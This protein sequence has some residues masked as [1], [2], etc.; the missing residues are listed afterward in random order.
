[1]T[2]SLDRPDNSPTMKWQTRTI[3]DL[4]ELAQ[5]RVEAI[6][7]AQ[8]LTRIA[9][10]YVAASTPEQRTWLEF[11]PHDA[12]IATGNFD[13]AITLEMRLPMLE[14]QF[15]ENGKPMP[16]VFDPEEHSPAEVEAWLLVELLHRGID[17][18]VFSKKLPYTIAGLMSGDAED[19]SPRL[20]GPGLI[21]LTALM[22]DAAAVLKAAA[23]SKG[24][25]QASI[26]CLPQNLNLVGP[27]DS[28]SFVFSLGDAESP[29]PYF[30][31][32]AGSS[33]GGGNLTIKAAALMAE[34]DPIAAAMKLR[35]LALG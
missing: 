35:D 24:G 1:M 2:N 31:R 3:G 13:K 32:R 14:L 30:Y 11:R 27:S 9:N 23:P 7:V 28:G 19:Y 25:D 5:A 34:C 33:G 15:L 4:S 20:C 22:R 10:S 29:E 18:G 6:N 26:A 16:H 17:R 21:R 8:W 12:A